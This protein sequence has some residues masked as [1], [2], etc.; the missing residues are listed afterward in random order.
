V[1]D[2]VHISAVIEQV[3]TSIEQRMN[4]YAARQSRPPRATVTC[5]A[6]TTGKKTPR[7]RPPTS[8]RHQGRGAGRGRAATMGG[9]GK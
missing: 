2:P 3:M 7:H 5:R 4:D 9:G 1:S 6:W 8:A